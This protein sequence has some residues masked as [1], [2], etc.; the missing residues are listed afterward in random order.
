M[1][2]GRRTTNDERIVAFL[3]R[4]LTYAQYR[5]LVE[6]GIGLTGPAG[7]RRWVAERDA[8]AFAKLYFGREFTLDLA[9]VHRTFTADIEAIRRRAL[10]A[11]PGLKVVRAIPRG[12]SKTSYYSRLLPLHGMLYGWSPLT[13]LLGNNATAAERLVKNIRAELESNAQILEDFGDV[14][15]P[16]WQVDHLQSSNGCAIR[17]FG[18]GSGAVRGVSR[19]G[20]P[21]LIVGDDLDDDAAVRSA[22]QL[23]AN[24][25]WWD[26]AVMQLG[27]QVAF[28]TSYA[29]IGTII[30]STSL[31]QHVLDSPDFQSTVAQGVLRFADNGALWDEW[32]SWYI[33]EAKAG[34]KPPGPA[35]DA[36]YQEHRAEMLAG[37][38]VLWERPD[39]YYHLMIYRLSR[40]EGAFWSEIQN[41][42]NEAGGNLGKLPLRARPTDLRGWELLGALDPTT[43]GGRTNDKAAWVEALFHRERKEILLSYVD[44][45]QRPYGATI[46]AVARR[47]RQTIAS[48]TRYS[49]LWCEANAA[50][51][52]IA[53]AIDGR[54]AEEQQYA[55]IVQVQ[56]SAPKDERIGMLSHYA[57]RQQLYA[58]DDIDPEFVQA[59]N[60]YPG[61]RFDDSLDAGATIVQELRKAGL[62]DLI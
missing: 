51:T 34:R 20:R 26:K 47:I 43:H 12:H 11:Q 4:H 37:T 57:A 38:Q 15:G 44:A 10:A 52:L 42:P 23:E 16:V 62:L 55:Y 14:R 17:C 13:V 21:S 27:D 1:D 41:L 24:T 45:A 60:G 2:D 29:V 35:E 61:Y 54:L 46:D 59:W 36:C 28:T 25:D 40:G 32:R 58:C 50:G 5:A 7:L 39:A 53:D 19:P 6:A 56:N 48:G 8:E 31:M 49:G 3:Q 9:P 18:A 30:K 22:V 33:A